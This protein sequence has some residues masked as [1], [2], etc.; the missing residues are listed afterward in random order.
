MLA[1]VRMLEDGEW[2][3]HFAKTP[4]GKRLEDAVT[5]LHSDLNE[6]TSALALQDTR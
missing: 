2:A 1:A 3:E 5:K 6:A 4:I